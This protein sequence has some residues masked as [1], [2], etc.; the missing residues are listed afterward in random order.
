VACTYGLPGPKWISEY[1]SRSST[2]ANGRIQTYK[3]AIWGCCWCSIANFYREHFIIR[4]V[5]QDTSTTLA[6]EN[7][8]LS[9]LRYCPLLLFTHACTVGLSE[10]AFAH[11]YDKLWQCHNRVWP[12]LFLGELKYHYVTYGYNLVRTG[13]WHTKWL[14]ST[15]LFLCFIHTNPPT[16]IWVRRYHLHS[17]DRKTLSMPRNAYKNYKCLGII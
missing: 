16:I 8:W 2:R 17:I 6:N 9:G 14:L 15:K 10:S 4:S 13:L 12:T 3:L 11:L 5:L 7:C 1:E